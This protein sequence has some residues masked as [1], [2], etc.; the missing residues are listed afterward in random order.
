MGRRNA[1]SRPRAVG[2]GRSEKY[3]RRRDAHG[4]QTQYAAE[5][6][7]AAAAAVLEHLRAG[8]KDGESLL[9]HSAQVLR[10]SQ[11]ARAFWTS[12]RKDVS[13]HDYALA[14]EV[15]SAHSSRVQQEGL[16]TAEVKAKT[17]SFLKPLRERASARGRDVLAQQQ[18]A[19]GRNVSC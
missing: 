2:G 9:E 17:K 19:A 13:P 16:S 14:E 12:L 18:S 4:S 10:D 7:D 1:H 3:T 11:E 5:W 6:S 15:M 8:C